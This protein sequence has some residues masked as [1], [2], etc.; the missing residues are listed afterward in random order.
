[1]KRILK[2]V[3]VDAFDLTMESISIDFLAT[4]VDNRG[5]GLRGGILGRGERYVRR[6]KSC[7]RRILPEWISWE[8]PSFYL[9]FIGCRCNDNRI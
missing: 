3:P 6:G 2:S 8:M 5:F 1:M 4:S 7:R 9:S